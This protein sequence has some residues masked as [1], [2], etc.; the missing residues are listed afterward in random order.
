M[1]T[2]ALW[3]AW[4]FLPLVRRSSATEEQGLLFDAWGVAELTGLSATVFVCNLYVLP[5]TLDGLLESPRET[6]DTVDE[7]LAAGWRVD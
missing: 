7:M 2:P 1:R 5:P 4:P 6:F 3:P